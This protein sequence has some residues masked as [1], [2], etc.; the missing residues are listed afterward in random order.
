[1]DITLADRRRI[2]GHLATLLLATAWTATALTAATIAYFEAGRIRVRRD[3]CTRIIADLL[4]ESHAYPPAPQTLTAWLMGHAEFAAT[5]RRRLQAPW[6]SEPPLTPARFQPATRFE[7]LD[8]PPLATPGDL[9]AWL[10]VTIVELDWFSGIRRPRDPT[11]IPVLQHYT[12]IFIPKKSG[13]PRLIEIPKPRLKTL[14]RRILDRILACLPAHPCAHGFVRGRSALTGAQV[15]AGESLIV[16][17]DL[18][19][20]FPSTPLRRVHGLFRSLGYPW[21]VARSLTGLVS[22]ATPEAVFTRRP[23]SEGHNFSNRKLHAGRH[24]PQ[25]AP[26][27]PALANL[28][29]WPL[30]QRLAG[31]ARAAGGTYTRYAD[32]IA[33]SGDA[34]FA[35]RA[36]RVVAAVGRIAAAEGYRLNASKTRLMAAHQRQCVTGI[37]VNAHAN[38]ARDD[39]D[40]LKALLHNCTRFG[41]ASQN[42]TAATDFRAHLD[43]R[44]HWVEQVNPQRGAKLRRLYDAIPW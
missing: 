39:F 19:D 16:S 30:D 25:G 5:A 4:A 37:V 26:T 14:Q 38:I 17:A 10:G 9:A 42:R 29:A 43:G 11:M 41:P 6:L 12:Y 2:A 21:A 8:I 1:M 15:H 40:T 44:V 34:A 7:A 20:F 33:L 3:R 23:V 13:A 28:C 27:S 35:T 22:T 36:P 18:A 31:L 24:L 32:D